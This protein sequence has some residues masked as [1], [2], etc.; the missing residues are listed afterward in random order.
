VIRMG[1]QNAKR[2]QAKARE[3]LSALRLGAAARR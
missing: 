3:L 1:S 2:V